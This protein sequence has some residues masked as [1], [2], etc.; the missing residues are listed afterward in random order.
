MRITVCCKRFAESGGAETFLRNFGRRLLAEGH[1]VAVLAAE[2]DADM[3]GVEFQRIHV[4]RVPRAFR[5][6]ALARASR[7][8]L[9]D[10]R[11]DVTFSDQKC[12][13]AQVVRCGGGCQREYV[14]QR[15]KSYPGLASRAVNR[16]ARKL[17]VRE[18]L[19][20]YI[21]DTLYEAPGPR[22]VIANSDMVRRELS[23]HY[24]HLTERIRVVY[25]GADPERFSP[26]LKDA[27]RAPVREELGIPMDALVGVFVGHDWRR[28]GLYPFIGAL[29]ILARKGTPKPAYGI[30]VGRGKRRRAEAHAAKAGAG[31]RLRFVGPARP[32]RYYGAADLLVLPSYYDPCA[33]VSL[34]AL[35]CGL[36]V[37]TSMFNGAYELLTPG[38]TGS[39]V[40]D[41]SDSAELAGFMEHYMDEDVL[42]TGSEAA[43]ALA[44]ERPLSR[45]YEEIIEAITPI[46]EEARGST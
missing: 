36:P 46:A 31:D 24:P 18:W 10:E 3:E 14:K 38:I 7:K 13:G 42:A 28:K 22:C 20:I 15:E 17:S 4:P 8:A 37:L 30:V 19:R 34:E 5:D 12:W 45:M 41:A 11:A 33:N 39:F 29:G 6:L 43:R 9:A 26:E 27:H 25:N 21:D 32:D 40:Q 1:G 16:V 23:S 44:M 2:G 35:A